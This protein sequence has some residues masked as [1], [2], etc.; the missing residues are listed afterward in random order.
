MHLNIGLSLRAD[1]RS[2]VERELVE[3]NIAGDR[4]HLAAEASDL[5]GQHAGSGDLDGVVPVVVVVTERIG[6]IQDC[7]LGY[8]G[9]VLGDVEVSGLHRP[10][11]YGVRNEEEVKFPVNYF[12]L[13]DEA[14]VHV[15]SLRGVLDEVLPVVACR[16]LEEPLTDSLVNDDQGNFGWFELGC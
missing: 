7:H 13:L 3:I 15:G 6:E 5:V 2:Q 10:L 8:L 4:A 11:G 12:G 14:L 1:A 9:G 16:L